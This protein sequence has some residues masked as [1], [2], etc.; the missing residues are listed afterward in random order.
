M[1]HKNT[2]AICKNRDDEQAKSIEERL[3]LVNDLVAAEAKYHVS[4]RVN[5]EKP[6][7]QNKTPGC[8]VSTENVTIFNQA[9][10]ILE[11]DVDLDTFSEFHNIRPSLGN[12]I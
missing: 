2:I 12:N 3:L 7:P 6:V 5:F 10:G 8:P 11:E 4:W 1:R 9:C